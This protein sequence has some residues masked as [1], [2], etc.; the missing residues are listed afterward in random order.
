MFAIS[1]S[2]ETSRSYITRLALAMLLLTASARAASSGCAPS[3][4]TFACRLSALL[5]WLQATA[6]VL[7]LVLVAVIAL[8]VYLIRKNKV[9]RKDPR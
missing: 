1:T 6:F 9:D 8:A 4:T 7:T 2:H 5:N 3:D